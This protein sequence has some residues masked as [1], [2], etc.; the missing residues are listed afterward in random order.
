[1]F[2]IA[3]G[4]KVL[5]MWRGLFLF[6]RNSYTNLFVLYQEVIR[7]F[8]WSLKKKKSRKTSQIIKRAKGKT[9][10]ISK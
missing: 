8:F 3:P 2:K 4:N 1:M 6:L 5:W 7:R 10:I 9:E